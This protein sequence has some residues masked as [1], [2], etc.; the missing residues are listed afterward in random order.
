MHYN[1]FIHYDEEGNECMSYEDYRK[2]SAEI[3]RREKAGLPSYDEE[4]GNKGTEE[5]SESIFSRILE[6]K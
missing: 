5:Y 4:Y 1:D 6:D 3:G 2:S